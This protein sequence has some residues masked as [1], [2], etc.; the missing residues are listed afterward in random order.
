MMTRE[1]YIRRIEEIETQKIESKHRQHEPCRAADDERIRV[2]NALTDAKDNYMK[3]FK[4]EMAAAQNLCSDT[5]KNV[6]RREEDL[7]LPSYQ[8]LCITRI[9]TRERL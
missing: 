5:C 6:R 3:K 2:Q 4:E 8:K 9:I 1:Q 7:R